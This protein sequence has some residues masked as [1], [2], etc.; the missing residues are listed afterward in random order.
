MSTITRSARGNP[1]TYRG[2]IWNFARRDLKARFRGTVLGWLWSLVLPLATLVIYT[3]VFSVIF[4]ATPPEF[5]NG[6]PGNYAVW[7]LVGMVTY[8][9]FAIG[10]NQA[11]PALL[12]AGTLL[13]K[14][15]IPSYVPVIGAS[16]ASS[17]QTLIEFG[18]LL[19]ILLVIMN[20][21]PTWLLFPVVLAIFFVFVVSVSLTL[22]VLN[23]YARD[24]QQITS[25]VVQLLFFLSPILYP[26]D[27]IPEEYRGIPV[28]DIMALNPLSVFITAI[29][30][31]L[32]DLQ[33]PS[34]SQFAVM[35]AWTVG[36]VL[37]AWFVYLRK[38]Q[39]I[40]EAV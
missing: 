23:V 10:V 24:L 34:L 29:R 35:L 30:N 4:R 37:L 39:D 2:L 32:Y 14:I 22:A 40:G 25:V 31:C 5:G 11:I 20:V 8:S 15:Y 13:Q 33:V 19:A 27:L 28:R 1:W 7:L 38:G 12:G 36:A 18:I 16:L 3:A 17:M 6:K 21:G 9:F 26:V